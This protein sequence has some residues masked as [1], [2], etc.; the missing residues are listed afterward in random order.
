MI[1]YE[2]TAPGVRHRGQR[3]FRW[4]R[5]I[6]AAYYEVGQPFPVYFVTD[7]PDLSYGPYPPSRTAF[8][9]FPIIFAALG[10][11]VIFFAYRL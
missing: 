4:G 7:K 1:T 6:P 3:L 11:T 10:I 8:V 5:S 2:Y 9:V